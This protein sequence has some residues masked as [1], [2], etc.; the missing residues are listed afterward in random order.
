MTLALLAWASFT[1]VVMLALAGV[2]AAALIPLT[3]LYLTTKALQPLVQGLTYARDYLGL[4]PA[5]WWGIERKP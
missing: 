4:T 3:A 5:W 1:A 2:G